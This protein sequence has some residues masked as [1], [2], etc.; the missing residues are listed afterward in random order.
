MSDDRRA[1]EFW[2]Q[3]L[4]YVR[5]PPRFEGDDWIVQAVTLPLRPHLTAAIFAMSA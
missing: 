4:G 1:G 2:R 3:A 5:R